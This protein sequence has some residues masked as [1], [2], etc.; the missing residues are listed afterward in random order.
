MTIMQATR[1]RLGV[2]VILGAVLVAAP[3]AAIEAAE[4]PT[5]IE[6]IHEIGRTFVDETGATNVVCCSQTPELTV[7][8]GIDSTGNVIAATYADGV[9]TG[10]RALRRR[11]E[12]A[13]APTAARR[14]RSRRRRRH[15]HRAT[16]VWSGP[17][18]R[19]RRRAASVRCGRY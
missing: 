5:T 4:P 1:G 17:A 10:C 13:P 19:T 14:P 9:F 16:S 6:D 12:A 2:G 18:R 8:Y 3:A 7:C 15:R 11:R